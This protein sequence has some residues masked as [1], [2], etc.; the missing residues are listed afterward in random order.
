MGPL[1]D[2]PGKDGSG[3]VRSLAIETS[4]RIGSV[5]LG[6]G[7]RVVDA[8]PFSTTLRH[9]VELLPTVDSICREHG[10]RP[11]AI[12]ELYVSGGPGSFTGLRI[13]ITFARG[14]AL[15]QGTRV[16]RVPTLEVIA[17]N[18]LGL[19]DAPSTLVVI[20]DAKRGRVF[21]APFGRSVE[22]YVA[23]QDPA[24]HDPAI[25]FAMLPDDC[26]ALGEGIAYHR[27]AVDRFRLRVLPDELNRAR[28]EVVHDLGFRRARANEFDDAR[29]LIPIYVRRPEAEEVWERRHDR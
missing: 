16:V 18:A 12:G 3:A 22:G 17:Q 6:I 13:G 1:A 26:A 4:G 9:A 5:A 21:A 15:A 23:T 19:A 24:E 25:L 14:L 7:G 20:L 27:E 11:G 29:G 10:I 2:S 8:R 28:A